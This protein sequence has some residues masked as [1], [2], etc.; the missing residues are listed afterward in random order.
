MQEP[1]R[2]DKDDGFALPPQGVRAGLN[3]LYGSY[4]LN[5]IPLLQNPVVIRISKQAGILE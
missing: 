3:F 1:H 4:D 5:N 2:G